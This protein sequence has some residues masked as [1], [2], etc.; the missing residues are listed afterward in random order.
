MTLEPNPISL[1]WLPPADAGWQQALGTT[2]AEDESGRAL[3]GLCSVRLGVAQLRAVRAAIDKGRANGASLSALRSVRLGIVGSGN[4]DFL[5]DVLPGTGP[6]FGLRVE[7]APVSYDGIVPAVFAAPDFGEPVDAVVV[8]P[9]A[10]FFQFPETL[11]DRAGHAQ[12]LEAACAR[13][14]MVVDRIQDR[15]AC[16]VVVATIPARPDFAP[17]LGERIVSGSERRFLAD[18]NLA[19]ADL[20]AERKLLLW[21]V[22]AIAADVGNRVWR[23]PIAMHVGKSPFAF[24][25]APLVADRLLATLAPLFG[26]S[27]RGLILDLDN[28]LWT[29]VIGDDGLAGI[30]IG[31]GS[32]VGEAHL[33]L[34]RLVLAY[35][36][37][38]V[39]IAVCSKNE[40]AIAREPFR[41]HP[42]MLLREEHV[43][44]FQANWTDKATNVKTIADTLA[45]NP[46]AFVFVDDNP[47]ERARVRQ[48]FPEIAVPELPDDPALFAMYLAGGGYFESSG[49]N[50]DDLNRAEAYAGN[51]RRAAI[52]EQLGDYG[53][54]LESLEMTL[55]ISPFDEI[56][57]GRI[58]QLIA[59]S[60]QFNLTT[61]RRQEAEVAQVEQSPAHIG[62]Q[63]RLKDAFGDN[64]MISVVIL[65]VADD[66]LVVDTWLMSCR[67]LER[68]VE[69]AVLNKIVALARARGL[70]YVV[71][72]YIPTDRNAMV[73]DHYARLGFAPL[74]GE[75]S[76]G[77]ETLWR[78]DAEAFSPFPMRMT[79]IDQA[80]ETPE[81]VS[82]I[83]AV[84]FT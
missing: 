18:L 4:L 35:R 61:R 24:S 82:A 47:A 15:H 3:R 33:A 28:T 13:L 19:I 42:D 77:S 16:P 68:E 1:F 12:A 80:V 56:G 43:A 70:R 7:V 44:V 40:D 84:D 73:R 46:E 64:G 75:Q 2:L 65:E 49:L 74:S 76:E 6:R 8:V 9:D 79:V 55:T 45:L 36:R 41:S 23:D 48:H 52:R 14:A 31:Q 63:I 51:A 32:A 83:G 69:H 17:M 27:R 60:N 62:L 38:G 25:L 57:R 29:G 53:A 66:S 20:A 71:G 34:Q 39:V 11:L 10:V 21:D 58:A 67:V 54:Y 22:E 78:L 72:R 30:V 5:A 81:L 26:K 59:K 37:L 50:A